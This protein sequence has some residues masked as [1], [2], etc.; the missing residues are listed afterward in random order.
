MNGK[1][2]A[3]ITRVAWGEIEVAIG[4][5]THRFKDC[6]IWPGGAVEWEWNQTGTRHQPG[7]QPA[8]LEEILAHDVEIVVLSRGMAGRLR[9][10]AD[11]EQL[12]KSKNIEYHIEKTR[13]ATDLFNELAKKGKKVGGI[14]HS[15]C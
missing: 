13:R 14:F 3:E 8:D 9:I 12:L 2:S 5:R 10:K 1:N 4:D 11:T 6:K 15:T 7:I